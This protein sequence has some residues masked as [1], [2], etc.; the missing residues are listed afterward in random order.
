MEASETE[1]LFGVVKEDVSRP[2]QIRLHKINV[3]TT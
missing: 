2:S 3:N 1:E